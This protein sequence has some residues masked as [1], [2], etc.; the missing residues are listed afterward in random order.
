MLAL[1]TTI[2]L[3]HSLSN[4]SFLA[5]YAGALVFLIVFEA[6]GKLGV[7]GDM[8]RLE[9]DT[10]EEEVDGKTNGVRHRHADLTEA[11]KGEEDAGALPLPSFCSTF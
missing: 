5:I 3:A 6:I 7:V 4:L 2:P 10:E 8:E 11:G 1:F 9:A